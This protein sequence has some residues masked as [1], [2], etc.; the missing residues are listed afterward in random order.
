MAVAGTAVAAAFPMAFVGEEIEQLCTFMNIA[1]R[2]QIKYQRN[3]M[4]EIRY[5]WNKK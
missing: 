1:S 4:T 5:I 2:Q 3:G